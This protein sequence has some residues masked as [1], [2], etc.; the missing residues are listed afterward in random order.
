MLVEPTVFA[1]RAAVPAHMSYDAL[2]DNRDRQPL[3]G[4]APFGAPAS[5]TQG[6]A[7]IGEILDGEKDD[8]SREHF[9]A[10]TGVLTDV[11]TRPFAEDDEGHLN[12]REVIAGRHGNPHRG[13]APSNRCI[14][15]R[16]TDKPAPA[17]RFQPP[18]SLRTPAVTAASLMVVWISGRKPFG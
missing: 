7:M 10:P 8:S 9:G 15:T 11:Q 1:P 6:P 13:N 17:S 3:S 5:R 14:E 12:G 18:S 2:F 4:Q 16:V